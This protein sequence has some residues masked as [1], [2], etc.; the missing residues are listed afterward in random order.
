MTPIPKEIN[1]PET[2]S[3]TGKRV[4]KE[5]NATGGTEHN[6]K[7]TSRRKEN[8]KKRFVRAHFKKSIH[9]KTLIPSLQGSGIRDRKGVHPEKLKKNHP[10][11]GGNMG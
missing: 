9:K 6:F 2:A 7:L 11:L 1:H 5:S 8:K 3:T 10:N 4:Q